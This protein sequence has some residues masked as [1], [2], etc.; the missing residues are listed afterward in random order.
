MWVCCCGCCVVC[1]GCCSWVMIG[2]WLMI[3][4]VL[5]LCLCCFGVCCLCLDVNCLCILM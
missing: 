2:G 1:C 3:G 4:L 5:R